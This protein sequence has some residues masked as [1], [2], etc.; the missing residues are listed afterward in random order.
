MLA[1]QIDRLEKDDLWHVNW[2][3]NEYFYR[4]RERER[5]D[6]NESDIYA[7]M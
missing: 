3:K 7:E 4:V 6:F 5:R 2:D 1:T